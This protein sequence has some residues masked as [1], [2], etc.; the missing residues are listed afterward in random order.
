VSIRAITGELYRL[1]KQVEQLERQLAATPPD[2]A[3]SAGLRD[4]LRTARAERDRLKGMLAG[5]KA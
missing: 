4:Q 2:A 5:A 3:D 1:M